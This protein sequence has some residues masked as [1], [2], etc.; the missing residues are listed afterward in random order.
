LVRRLVQGTRVYILKDENGAIRL[1]EL[2]KVKID[3]ICS[4][5]GLEGPFGR[6]VDEEPPMT[7]LQSI[8]HKDWISASGEFILDADELGISKQRMLIRMFDI[9]LFRDYNDFSYYYLSNSGQ[10][11][12]YSDLQYKTVQQMQD[13]FRTDSNK[14]MVV[15][16]DKGDERFIPSEMQQSPC[17]RIMKICQNTEYLDSLY[18][19]C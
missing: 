2:S 10:A 11:S 7:T 14:F 18:V 8:S 12:P 6:N 9:N 3:Y 17:V 1:E 16:C 4:S 13:I 19:K 5:I 15:F